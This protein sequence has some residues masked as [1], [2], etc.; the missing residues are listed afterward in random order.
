MTVVLLSG[1]GSDDSDF[2]STTRMSELDKRSSISGE[3][4]VE[5][6]ATKGVMQFAKVSV[7]ELDAQ[8]RKLMQVGE[9]ETDEEGIYR[10]TLADGYKHGVLEVVVS[11]ANPRTKM[12]CDAFQCGA[13]FAGGAV[14][15]PD[16]FTLHALASGDNFQDGEQSI[17][18]SAWTSLA[19]ER[20]RA[21]VNQG[22]RINDALRRAD[23]ELN[24]LL[25]FNIRKSRSRSLSQITDSGSVE[26]QYAV[27]NAAAAEILFDHGNFST[28]RFGRFSRSMNDG[29]LAADDFVTP[30]KLAG[31]IESV[32]QRSVR[33]N[34]QAT[35]ALNNLSGRLATSSEWTPGFN[36]DLLLTA[37]A[38]KAEKIAAF[39]RFISPIRSW[40]GVIEEL[41]KDALQLIA[42][43]DREAIAKAVDEGSQA[44]LKFIGDLVSQSSGYMSANLDNLK[45]VLTSGGPIHFAY[46]DWRGR[47][48]GAIALSF[49]DGDGFTI[50]LEGSVVGESS[51][52]FLPFSIR[53]ATE[54]SRIE[55][56]SATEQ[57]FRSL[58]EQRK[59]L[60]SG[61]VGDR[62]GVRRLVL[63]ELSLTLSPTDVAQAATAAE[64]MQS[65]GL[66][67][68]I[69]IH[70]ADASFAGRI[71]VNFVRPHKEITWLNGTTSTPVSL[72]SFKLRG[73]FS[74][75]EGISTS[76]LVSV[77]LRNATAI[78]L[79]AWYEGGSEKRFI[80]FPISD[81]D[82]SALAKQ[83]FPITGLMQD[84]HSFSKVKIDAFENHL[85]ARGFSGQRE[86]PDF[87][88]CLED[89]QTILESMGEVNLLDEY[90]AKRA[91]AE[92]TLL[93]HTIEQRAQLSTEFRRWRDEV[94]RDYL[95]H[96]YGADKELASRIE[97]LDVWAD[98]WTTPDLSLRGRMGI[99]FRLPEFEESESN[100]V[101]GAFTL[102]TWV[103]VPELQSA[104]LTATVDRNSYRG[105][106]LLATVAARGGSY[107]LSLAAADID[108]P[109]SVSLRLFNAQ[110]YEL[111]IDISFHD[112]E[113]SR[114]SG[115]ASINDETVG[116][117]E[118][119]GDLPFLVYP[120]G[121]Q[122]VMES[123]L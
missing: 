45:D 105:G 84:L 31:A 17:S 72:R 111:N 44:Q 96:H 106:M 62:Q 58:L 102:S 116:L 22:Y 112:G 78:D 47:Q 108:N 49:P 41:D 29:S 28:E 12:I 74:T 10:V 104:Q 63:N 11:V 23:A 69:R 89:P 36:D 114:L 57:R 25:G 70:N 115:T 13:R 97:A 7:F 27:M 8:G 6:V 107:S 50:N 119:R 2:S 37:N 76:T 67:G 118:M 60:I 110:G 88:A 40:I 30:R 15:L 20:S 71:E 66:L 21:L 100:F 18:V 9:T 117:L 56:I 79:V 122:T 113:L 93:P 42:G 73:D 65:I 83:L 68:D 59:L 80:E 35:A 46:R 64:N 98:L 55:V 26:T 77:N 82:L 86:L 92:A 5:G 90:E 1:C 33:L 39:Q 94:V 95:E 75:A 120:N 121:G 91:C 101:E 14:T 87:K 85:H 34:H 32:L 103:S 24:E 4:V 19:S 48:V 52:N 53:I 81:E 16:D 3:T 61:H 38:T 123:L 51:A 109:R 43:V 54:I 99:Q